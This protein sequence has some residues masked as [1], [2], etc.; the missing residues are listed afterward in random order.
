M[1]KK[2]TTPDLDGASG[3]KGHVMKV[4]VQLLN[5]KGRTVPVAQLRVQKRFS[6][7]LSIGEVRS[8][9]FGRTLIAAHLRS[10]DGE[11]LLP[12]LHDAVVLRYECGRMRIR[13]VEVLN[14]AQH[15]QTWD[16]KV[17]AC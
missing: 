10:A 14:G 16:V 13:G 6:G 7:V 2:S 15:G 9:E 17:A 8:T 3:Q 4:E 11:E 12:L 5:D 1:Y